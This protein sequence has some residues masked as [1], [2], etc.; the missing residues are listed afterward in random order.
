MFRKEETKVEIDGSLCEPTLE[1]QRV[2]AIPEEFLITALEANM[3]RFGR[4]CSEQYIHDPTMNLRTQ[5]ICLVITLIRSRID[6][7]NRN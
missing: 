2:A 4:F 1:P 3:S 7:F 5:K 6:M